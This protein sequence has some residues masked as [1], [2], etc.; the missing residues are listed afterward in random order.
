LSIVA[1]K[2][3]RV[4][5]SNSACRRDGAP[6]TLCLGRAGPPAVRGPRKSKPGRKKLLN[7]LWKQLR[8]E[9]AKG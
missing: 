9:P 7:Y 6:R 3:L 2:Y 1:H 5:A 4:A 8:N